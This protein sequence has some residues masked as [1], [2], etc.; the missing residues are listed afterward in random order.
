MAKQ[1]SKTLQQS[2]NSYGHRSSNT[3]TKTYQLPDPK[4]GLSVSKILKSER[5]L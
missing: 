4:S 1:L 5:M 3:T 2:K